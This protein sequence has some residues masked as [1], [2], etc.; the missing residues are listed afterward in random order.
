MVLFLYTL[1]YIFGGINTQIIHV[2]AIGV[3]CICLC[4]PVVNVPQTNGLVQVI[5]GGFHL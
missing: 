3:G 2:E 5:S 4:L 1:L